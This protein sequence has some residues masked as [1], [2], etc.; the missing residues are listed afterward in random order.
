MEYKIQDHPVYRALETR[1]LVMDGAMGS[2]IQ[3]Y[4]LTESDFRGTR[5]ENFPHDLKG[6]NDLLSITRPEIINDIHE[7]YLEAGADKVKRV[8]CAGILDC[9]F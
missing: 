3:E 1:V 2:L 5:F 8:V 6:N 7:K 4:G 9:H